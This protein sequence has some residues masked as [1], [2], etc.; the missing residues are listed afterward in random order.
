M[1]LKPVDG[2]RGKIRRP[3]A[4]K[5]EITFGNLKLDTTYK[6]WVRG[7]N[8]AGKGDRTHVTIVTTRGYRQCDS[9]GF[10]A[11]TRPIPQ[12]VWDRLSPRD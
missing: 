10:C 1:H 3:K 9:D 8:A 6:I 4:S 2:G 11:G 12:D 5:T 7:R